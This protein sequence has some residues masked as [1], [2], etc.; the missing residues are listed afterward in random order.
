MPK[1]YQSL[2]K[3]IEEMKVTELNDF[4]KE[5][6]KKFG[7]VVA[8]AAPAAGGEAKEEK[9]QEKSEYNI[10]L[11]NAGSNKIA[12]IKLVK[13][14]TEKGLVE[15][16]QISESLPAMLKEK[17]KKEEAEE[18]KKKFEDAGASVELK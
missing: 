4:V 12:V 18:I 9:A 5:L 2:I 1:K 14:I 8:S 6:E 17:V 11:I 16:K 13:E 3:K 10:E 7:P 15:A